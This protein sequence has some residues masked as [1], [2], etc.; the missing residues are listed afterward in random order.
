ME[1]PLGSSFLCIAKQSCYLWRLPRTFD[2]ERH[3][4]NHCQIIYSFYPLSQL[5]G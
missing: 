3:P 1:N 5:S 4:Q 2:R